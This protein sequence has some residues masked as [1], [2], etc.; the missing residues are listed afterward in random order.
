MGASEHFSLKSL[1]LFSV[2]VVILLLL[3]CAALYNLTKGTDKIE[4]WISV[5]SSSSGYLL[6]NPKL[7]RKV[8]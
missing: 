5:L 1:V 6:P 2:Q 8:T 3:I 4:F 7:D